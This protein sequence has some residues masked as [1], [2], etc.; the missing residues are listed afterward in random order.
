MAVLHRISKEKELFI[1]DVVWIEQ[2]T[3]GYKVDIRNADG[4]IEHITT[5]W[6]INDKGPHSDMIAHFLGDEKS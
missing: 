3:G 6:V 2:I 5:E 4:D 1:S